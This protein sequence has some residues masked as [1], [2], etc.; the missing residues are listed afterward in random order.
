MF[1]NMSETP[2][3][4]AACIPLF[5]LFEEWIL[6]SDN[7][8]LV[9]FGHEQFR[10][11]VSSSYSD[12]STS[13]VSMSNVSTSNV[14]LCRAL[15]E[16]HVSVFYDFINPNLVIDVFT[17][18]IHTSKV[19]LVRFVSDLLDLLHG[20]HQQLWEHAE[21]RRSIVNVTRSHLFSELTL[22]EVSMVRVNTSSLQHTSGRTGST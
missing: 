8:M 5:R 4:P 9:Q 20:P 16:R 11:D 17:N 3:A 7:P 10:C 2:M 18:P 22:S 21:L 6:V 14:S 19:E 15:A 12:M 13:D 1:A